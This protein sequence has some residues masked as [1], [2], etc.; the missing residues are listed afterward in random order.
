MCTE[1]TNKIRMIIKHSLTTLLRYIAKAICRIGA[2]YTDREIERTRK[3]L[4]NGGCGYDVDAMRQLWLGNDVE[5][6]GRTYQ[7]DECKWLATLDLSVKLGMLT[8]RQRQ[9]YIDTCKRDWSK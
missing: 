9:W 6:N 5:S 7:L 8:E 3:A 1:M 2:W 4:A